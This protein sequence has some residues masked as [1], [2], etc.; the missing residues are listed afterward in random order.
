MKNILIAIICLIASNMKG[1]R[2]TMINNTGCSYVIGSAYIE[3]GIT[4]APG[5][6]WSGIVYNVGIAP[7]SNTT[8]LANSSSFPM[9]SGVNW[10]TAVWSYVVL[11]TTNATTSDKVEVWDVNSSFSGY[12]TSIPALVGIPFIS[13]GGISTM[14]P[15]ALTPNTVPACGAMTI[16]LDNV[17]YGPSN[18]VLT[19]N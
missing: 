2:L 8:V 5:Y 19:I 3:D 17:T 9:N 7:L 14:G 16:T 4:T 13:S 12:A 10:S 18:P 11:G 6:R 15:G 1:Q